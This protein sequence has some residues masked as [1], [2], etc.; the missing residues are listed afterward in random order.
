[1]SR[2]SVAGNAA[3]LLAANLLAGVLN[4][5]FQLRA[6]SRLDLASYGSLNVWMA[7]L[8]LAM[9]LGTALQFASNF[10]PLKTAGLKRLGWALW[11]L[12]PGVLILTSNLAYPENTPGVLGFLTLVLGLA[13]HLAL[14]QLQGRFQFIWLGLGIVVPACLK[15]AVA[16]W[17][18]VVE[19]GTLWWALPASYALAL[20]VLGFGVLTLAA[21]KGSENFAAGSASPRRLRENLP[22]SLVLASAF[23]LAPQLDLLNL[24]QIHSPEVLG[25]YVR[26]ALFSKAIFFGASTL[27]QLALP[28]HIAEARGVRESGPKASRNSMLR[29]WEAAGLLLCLAGALVFSAVGPWITSRFLGFEVTEPRWILLS[30]LS[31]T[32]WYGVLQRLQVDC[33]L[34]RWKRATI[35]LAAVLLFSAAIQAAH[36][37][38]VTRYL[39]WA[40]AFYAALGAPS[41]LS[42]FRPRQVH[43]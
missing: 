17:P 11:L 40:T 12:G 18:G 33:A 19:P 34:G 35:V 41:F 8:N 30:C 29:L 36:P 43:A 26:A 22:S 16:F 13:Y 4:Y 31:L 39:A 7:W 37:S 2:R 9:I 32:S 27:L 5:C 38:E 1:M 20:V 28:Y 23:A 25:Q 24:T 10:H 21:G 3:V 15:F 42:I 14:G 6:A